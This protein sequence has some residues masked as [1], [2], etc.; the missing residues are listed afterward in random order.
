[1]DWCAVTMRA[2]GLPVHGFAAPNGL[3]AEVPPHLLGRQLA[4]LD[5]TV[6]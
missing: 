3:D 5:C 6:L 4:Q 2:E 1:M